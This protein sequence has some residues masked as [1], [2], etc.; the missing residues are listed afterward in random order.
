MLSDEKKLTLH[1]DMPNERDKICAFGKAL[2]IPD[3]VRIL[4]LLGTR[5]MNLNE[6]SK[7]LDIPVSSVSNHINALSEAELVLVTYQPSAKG[8]VK[9]CSSMVTSAEVKYKLQGSH[10]QGNEYSIE[11]PVGMYC[12]CNVSAPCGIVGA[13]KRLVMFDMPDYF[14]SPERKD[15]ELLWFEY[16]YVSY[17]FP[18]AVTGGGVPHPNEIS[19]SLEICS[20]APYYRDVW[21]SDITFLINDIEVLTWTSPGDFGGRRGIYT[22]K[23]WSTASSQFG[24]LKKI[25]VSSTGVYLDNRLMHKNVRIADLGIA[26]GKTVKFTVQIKEDAEHRGGINIYGK[27]F[28]DFPQAIIMTIK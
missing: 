14:Y 8:H 7:E 17:R 1:V 9:M 21:P 15:A 26:N 13:E 10:E 18:Y 2:S 25:S 3:R 28:G 11:M 22:P 27:N 16:G 5:A 6:I 24:L 19:F 4:E 23:Y 12:D 20:E